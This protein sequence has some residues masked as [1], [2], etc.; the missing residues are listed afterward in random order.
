MIKF[1]SFIDKV[2]HKCMI[3]YNRRLF[4]E[5]TGQSVS[6]TIFMGNVQLR[7]KNVTIGKGV[8]FRGD[9]IFDGDGPIVIGN[10]V[11]I[12]HG[13]IILA[14]KDGGVYIGDRTG[15]APYVYIIDMDHSVKKGEDYRSQPD[16]VGKIT[17]GNN[18][19]IAQNCTILKGSLI[20][21]NA[22]IGAKSLVKGVIEE[23]SIAVGIP[24]KII[25]WRQ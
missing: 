18:V 12:N 19:W 13:T 24:A 1:I 4:K 8:H 11:R 5:K 3:E 10:D 21:D 9:I 20:G 25:K 2:R 16:S 7:N 15:I 6:D 22:V 17:I 14:S 23:N